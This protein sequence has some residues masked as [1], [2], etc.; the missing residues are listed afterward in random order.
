MA[1]LSLRIN[2]EP[3]GAALGPGMVQ[4]LEQ[5]AAHG[6]IRAAA[7]SM[8]MSYRKA[9]LLIQKMQATFGGAVVTSAIGGSTGGGSQLTQLGVVLLETFRRV[10]R[11]AASATE[12][13][14]RTLD[15]MVKA[16][17]KP[18]DPARRKR[19]KPG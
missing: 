16:D 2:F 6:S 14:L 15:G 4:L 12:S 3:P 9:W 8:N 7:A 11:S 10:E 17:V 5:V 13:D 19:A 1:R 18:R